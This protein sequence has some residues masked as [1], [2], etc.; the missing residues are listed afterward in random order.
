MGPVVTTGPVPLPPPQFCT[1]RPGVNYVLAN[2]FICWVPIFTVQAAAHQIIAAT[3]AL[4]GP[5]LHQG[6]RPMWAKPSRRTKKPHQ[7]SA[8]P[9]SWSSFTKTRRRSCPSSSWEETIGLLYQRAPILPT[10]PQ[11]SPRPPPPTPPH[12]RLSEAKKNQIAHN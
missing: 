7:S 4:W 11:R 1:H 8:T 6:S 2:E 9:S 3:R 12:R 5:L 10:Q